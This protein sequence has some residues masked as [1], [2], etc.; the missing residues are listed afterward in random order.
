MAIGASEN[1][2]TCCPTHRVGWA[3]IRSAQ[4]RPGSSRQE[5]RHD[6]GAAAGRPD[7]HRAEI[8]ED[9]R[10]LTIAAAPERRGRRQGERLGQQRLRQRREER[11][12]AGVLQHAAADGVD[13]GDRAAAAGLGQPDD[14][15]PG[16]RPQR[17]RIRPQCVDASHDDVDRL[18]PARRPHPE[19]PAADRQVGALHERQPEQGRH[20]GLVEGGLGVRART[21]HDHPRFFGGR[22]RDRLE[23]Q[24][25]GVEVGAQPSWRTPAEG[26]R[27][28]LRH[29][30]AI[31][32]RVARTRRGLGPVAEDADLTVAPPV[33]VRRVEE[34]LMLTGDPD[35]VRRAE[36]VVVFEDEL[37]RD[38]PARDQGL[39]TVEIG[40]DRVEQHRPLDQPGLEATPLG[41]FDDQR[42]RV[43]SPPLDG[44]LADPVPGRRSVRTGGLRY[45][46]AD[47][48]VR[49]AGPSDGGCA[50]HRRVGHAVVLEQ[51]VDSGPQVAQAGAAE[52]VDR[53]RQV[54]PARV[55]I[56]VRGGHLV[57]PGR[58]TG[59][60]QEAVP[61]DVGLHERRRHRA[62]R[63][64]RRRGHT[65]TV[66]ERV[67]SRAPGF[68]G[69]PASRGRRRR[70]PAAPPARAAGRRRPGRWC[71]RRCRTGVIGALRPPSR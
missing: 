38:Q 11:Q 50:H 7:D 19:P 37:G 52:A 21:Q 17:E 35:A 31:G 13:D 16:V 8:R 64:L 60:G 3:E 55:Q 4:R 48:H 5:R 15:E 29:H 41:R 34:Q 12:Q 20:R 43:E 66:R 1:A 9:V 51:P 68:G 28:H 53:R 70:P 26:L 56:A 61:T 18:V 54:R 46:G 39:G 67:T 49:L 25:D 59:A 71:G 69:G 58:V 10:P 24:S 30:S 2:S 36:V 65:R 42:E 22:R 44:G 6:R 33:D 14:T 40:E 45:V 57:E 62:R 27:E 63:S 47:R 23:R 32:H